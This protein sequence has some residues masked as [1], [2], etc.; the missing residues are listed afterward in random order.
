[1]DLGMPLI[2]GNKSIGIMTATVEGQ[3]NLAVFTSILAHLD[4]IVAIKDRT[5]MSTAYIPPRTFARYDW[6]TNYYPLPIWVNGQPYIPV[7]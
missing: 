2:S 4:D 3:E 6:P 7:K 1:M 5:R